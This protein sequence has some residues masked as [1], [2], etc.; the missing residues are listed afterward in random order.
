MYNPTTF[1]FVTRPPLRIADDLETPFIV[2]TIPFTNSAILNGVIAL[3]VFRPSIVSLHGLSPGVVFSSVLKG[4]LEGGRLIHWFPIRTN[5]PLSLI[6]RHQVISAAQA[7]LFVGYGDLFPHDNRNVFS[8]RFIRAL[9]GNYGGLDKRSKAAHTFV[10]KSITTEVN[11]L[12]NK[13]VNLLRVYALESD[14]KN[15]IASKMNHN[16]VGLSLRRASRD[17]VELE[18]SN[19]LNVFL[20]GTMLSDSNDRKIASW[21]EFL[22]VEFDSYESW[23]EWFLSLRMSLR[24]KN[25]M[26]GIDFILG[27]WLHCELPTRGALNIISSPTSMVLTL[28]LP[29]RTD[30]TDYFKTIDEDT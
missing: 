6:L 24:L 27:S 30:L 29:P 11:S 17:G 3:V 9:H 2:V 23:L 20:V 10:W 26:E 15:T 22:Y 13:G 18:Q 1:S 8:S 28:D 16:D 21:W 4:G 19:N 5:G 7:T 25:I 12:R 14:K